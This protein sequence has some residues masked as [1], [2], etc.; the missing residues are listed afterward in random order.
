MNS[1]DRYWCG[2]VSSYP[3]RANSFVSSLHL[4]LPPQFYPQWLVSSLLVAVSPVSLLLTLSSSE[5]QM[6]FFSTN[7]RTLPPSKHLFYRIPFHPLH[8]LG[9]W[10]VIQRRPRPVS[11]APEPRASKTSASRTVPGY[12]STIPRNLYVSEH[13]TRSPHYFNPSTGSRPCS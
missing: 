6:S 2:N 5:A 13:R 8:P 11:T 3:G 4:H 1:R 7:N 12:S 10:V 9:L